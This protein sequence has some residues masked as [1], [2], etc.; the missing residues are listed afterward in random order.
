[1]VI[2]EVAELWNADKK[3]YVKEST[4][5]AYSLIIVNHIIP[6]FGEKEMFVEDD[7][8]KFVLDSLKKGL[9]EKTVKDVVVVIKMIQ[10]F[11][12]KKNLMALMPIDIKYPKNS[13][14]KELKVMSKENQKMLLSYLNDNFSF[15][16]LGI[17]ICLCSGL[18]IGELCALKWENFDIG[19]KVVKI[20]HSLQRIYVVDGESKYTKIK[21]DMPKTKES[22]RDIPLTNYLYSIIRPLKKVCKDTFYVLSND[23]KPIEP[24]TYRNYYKRILLKLGI[25]YLKFHGLRHSFATRCIESKN[26]VKTVSV[27]LGH[28]NVTTTLNL[29]VHPNNDE[30]KR[31]IEKMLKD[32]L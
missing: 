7:V 12:I 24:R 19:N 31:C 10:K 9:S 16:N 22:N 18:R 14:K 4:Y 28:A 2:K 29:Y 17:V 23:E 5:S 25:P 8:Q 3:Q 13:A 1:M 32:I 30:K 27:I 15:K 21:E 26:N 11:A 20:N 6:Y